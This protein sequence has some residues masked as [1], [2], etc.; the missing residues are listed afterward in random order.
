MKM[1]ITDFLAHLEQKMR[2]DEN[3][4]YHA[5]TGEITGASFYDPDTGVRDTPRLYVDLDADIPV[6]HAHVIVIEIEEWM[7][8]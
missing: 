6:G 2:K 5:C 1:T 8:E 3:G 4:E 7:Q